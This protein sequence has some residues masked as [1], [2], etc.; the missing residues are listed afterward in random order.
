MVTE[1]TFAAVLVA[2]ALATTAARAADIE[3]LPALSVDPGAITVSGIS[4]GGFM[5]HQMHIAHAATIAGAAVIAGGPYHCAGRGYPANLAR[6][7]SVC[8]DLSRWTPFL[9]PPDVDRLE[10]ETLAQAA[11]GAI[12][13][14]SGLRQDRVFLFSGSGDDLVP[15]SILASV[16]DYYGRFLAPARIRLVDD[17]PAAHAMVTAGFGGA[18]GVAEPPF[19]VDCDYDLAGTLLGHL[20]GPLQPPAAPGPVSAFDQSDFTDDAAAARLAPVGYVYVP[21]R[22]RQGTRCA[23]HVAF[24]GCLQN[25]AMIGDA[26]VAHAGYNGWAEANAIVVLYPQTAA[27]DDS[28]LGLDALSENPMGCWDWWGY[29]GP[30]FHLQSGRQVRAVKA[31]I[32]RLTARP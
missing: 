14:P 23:L 32:N 1:K 15:T 12:D 4:S 3:P 28:L 17:V 16:R 22:C 2:L 9:G 27:D 29:T 26:F 25:A 20:H 18:C 19:I 24:H 21:E 31:M 10:R 30:D 6:A 5:A 13:D 11:A 7:L 8:M